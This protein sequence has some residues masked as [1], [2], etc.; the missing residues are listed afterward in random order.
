MNNTLKI[1]IAG[2]PGTGKS[3]V[4]R[5]ISNMLSAHDIEC[6]IVEC[7]GQPLDN[8]PE[9]LALRLESLRNTVIK[10]ETV[11]TTRECGPPL[12]AILSEA[13]AAERQAMTDYPRWPDDPVHALH[14]I[15]EAVNSVGKEV[16]HATYTGSRDRAP[17]RRELVYTM[18]MILRFSRS[19]DNHSYR[20]KPVYKHV[21]QD[22]T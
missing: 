13:A 10:L 1:R 9:T 8:D 7:D 5:A 18:A 4:A 11:Q 17:I 21:Q 2:G 22:P 12:P 20:L 15:T 16:L 6:Q 3:T 14:V 19:L